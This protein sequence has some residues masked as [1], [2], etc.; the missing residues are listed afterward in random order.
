MSCCPHPPPPQFPLPVETELQLSLDL[1]GGWVR[2][3]VTGGGACSVQTI[4]GYR[5]FHLPVPPPIPS[6]DADMVV[7][8]RVA[9]FGARVPTGNE[10]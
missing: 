1:W 4:C 3:S 8:L 2:P 10:S 5:L 6:Q 9:M 7:G